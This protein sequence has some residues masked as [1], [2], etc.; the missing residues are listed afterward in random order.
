MIVNQYFPPVEDYEVKR[1][2]RPYTK[3]V[4]VAA[5][6]VAV[7]VLI[8][9][10]M[11][12]ISVWQIYSKPA[13]GLELRFPSSWEKWSEEDSPNIQLL[14]KYV[15][16]SQGYIMGEAWILAEPVWENT[17]LENF[18]N[19]ARNML[20]NYIKTGWGTSSI[21]VTTILELPCTVGGENGL[22]W[23]ADISF[24]TESLGKAISKTISHDNRFY[25]F[26]FH[27][28]HVYVKPPY[29]STS[30]YEFYQ[31]F[32]SDFKSMVQSVRFI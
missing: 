21:N 13:W 31:Q 12:G 28:Y 23:S 11:K 15:M 22:E 14:T 8:I 9:P 32:E 17:A 3:L 5:V 6:L 25:S 26:V 16:F 29:T 24:Y 1:R 30:A 20:I 2:I 10:L 7:L 4:L 18:E 27:A 19:N